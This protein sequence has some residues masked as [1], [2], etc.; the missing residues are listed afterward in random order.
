MDQNKFCPIIK[1]PCKGD[2][3]LA[4][5]VSGC[6]VLNFFANFINLN[7]LNTEKTHISKEQ[8]IKDEA[9]AEQLLPDCLEWA[10]SKN[11]TR[12]TREEIKT[13]L[14]VKGITICEAA[15]RIL[16][17][18]AKV[19]LRESKREM[20]ILASQKW[21][22]NK[23]NIGLAWSSDED[24][25]LL[26]GFDSGKSSFDLSKDHKRT[27]RAIELRLAKYGKIQLIK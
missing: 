27:V 26:K 5:D 11:I 13:F 3:C 1:D 14:T 8:I 22:E 10:L 9:K 17:R 21:R 19:K 24:D 2:L 4:W 6:T 18:Q 25:A 7:R 23:S 12:P 15:M 16:W 20:D